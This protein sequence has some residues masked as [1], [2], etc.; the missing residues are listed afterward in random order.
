VIW[1]VGGV[2]PPAHVFG[3]VAD[4]A[5]LP[6]S[7]VVAVDRQARELHVFGP[8]GEL[9]ERLGGEGEGPGELLDPIAVDVSGTT[10][11]VWDW[12]QS[13]VT[14]YDLETGAVETYPAAGQLNP[15]HHFGLAAQGFVFGTTTGLE[16]GGEGE[17]WTSDLGVIL[18]D[19]NTGRVDTLL[20]VPDRTS[21]WVDQSQAR[22]GSPHFSP[23]ASLTTSGGRIYVARGD[24]ARAFSVGA[25]GVDTLRWEWPVRPV[26]S[27]DVE[28]YRV[29]WRSQ[30]PMEQRGEIDRMFQ[31]MPAAEVFPSVAE[32]IPDRDGGLWVQAYTPPM[33]STRTWMRFEA[34]EMVCRVELPRS[35]AAKEGGADWLLGVASDELGVHR[36]ELRAVGPP[37]P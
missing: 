17:F 16:P 15:T 24:S 4:L 13:R 37:A 34:G 9:V 25:G 30:L 10:A 36:I 8:D 5:R 26:S 6:D 7:T 11:F 20:N 33:D 29:L 27:A 2:E 3:S 14:A 1:S 28:A 22:T 18:L 35:F 12:D 23:R 32:L 19:A 31:V 21:G